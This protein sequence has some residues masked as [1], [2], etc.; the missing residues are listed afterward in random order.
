M[1]SLKRNKFK[2]YIIVTF[3]KPDFSLCLDH[4][5]RQVKLLFR[6][7]FKKPSSTF[8]DT[9]GQLLNKPTKI[10]LTNSKFA[11]LSVSEFSPTKTSKLPA[12]ATFSILML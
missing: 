2:I 1:F 3:Q 11:F 10:Y 9:G 7:T 8:F 4:K 12:S 5:K 6:N